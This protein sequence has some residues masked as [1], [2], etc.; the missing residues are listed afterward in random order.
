MNILL[1]EDNVKLGKELIRSFGDRQCDC[2]LV[3]TLASARMQLTSARF[4]VVVLDLGLPD[5]EG[6]ELIEFMKETQIDT[7]VLIL[8]ARADIAD[9]VRGLR[10][11]ADDYM[12]KPFQIEELMAR[13]EVIVARRQ[14]KRQS[15][16][17][18]ANLQ[19][20]LPEEVVHVDGNYVS[21]PRREAALL[22]ILMRRKGR[23]VLKSAIEEQLFSPDQELGS[24]AVEVYVHRLRRRLQETGATVSLHTVRG[25]GYCLKDETADRQ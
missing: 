7:P 9:R 10:S 21:V 15:I 16:L 23:V 8:T 14:P 24:N 22:C 25:V 17:S 6:Y 13:L 4:D 11:G 1:V 5:G 20:M 18:M 3:A 19:M 2:I 12:T